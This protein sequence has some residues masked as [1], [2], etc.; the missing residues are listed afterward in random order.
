[1]TTRTERA[2]DACDDLLDQIIEQEE[3]IEEQML[4]IEGLQTPTRYVEFVLV[5]I[6]AYIYGIFFGVY[7]CPK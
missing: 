1:M 7:V 4:V 2:M 5:C 6:L 3:I